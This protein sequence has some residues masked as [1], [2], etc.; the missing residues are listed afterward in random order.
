M[1][2][3]YFSFSKD[4]FEWQSGGFYKLVHSKC[5]TTKVVM[6]LPA[7]KVEKCKPWEKPLGKNLRYSGNKLAE[8]YQEQ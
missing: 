3:I 4:S 1:R 8:N 7:T 5:S 2:P 6:V